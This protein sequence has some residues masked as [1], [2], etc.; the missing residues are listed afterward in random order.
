MLIRILTQDK[1]RK[2]LLRTVAE[3]FPAFTAYKTIGW[4]NGGKERSLVVEIDTPVWVGTKI[5]TLC[6]KIKGY[7]KQESV[8]VQKVDVDSEFY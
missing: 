2:W 5:R 7:N 6:L 1:N 3:Y 4:W 8:L